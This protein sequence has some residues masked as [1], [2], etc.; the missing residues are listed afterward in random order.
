M[1][2]LG[3]TFEDIFSRYFFGV[4]VG[5]QPETSVLCRQQT[6]ALSTDKIGLFYPKKTPYFKKQISIGDVTFDV[7]MNES[8]TTIQFILFNRKLYY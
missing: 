4:A 3:N 7:N 8:P 2:G 5:T 6:R 1:V